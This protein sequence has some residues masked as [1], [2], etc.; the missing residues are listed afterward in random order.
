[1]SGLLL[2]DSPVLYAL[3]L[4]FSSPELLLFDEQ[5]HLPVCGMI[6]RPM[7]G[8]FVAEMVVAG[9]VFALVAVVMMVVVVVAVAVAV[10]VVV[11]TVT[12]GAD[13]VVEMFAQ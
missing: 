8:G 10:V 6:V 9:E 7:V 11:I 13:S 4:S 1:M 3:E 2:H 5:Y 12:V